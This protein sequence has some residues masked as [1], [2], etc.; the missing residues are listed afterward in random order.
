MTIQRIVKF[1]SNVQLDVF[2]SKKL[3]TVEPGDGLDPSRAAQAL[4][5]RFRF[6]YSFRI[7]R[8]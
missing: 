6:P 8:I 1:P 3:Q 5:N 4:S 2:E 7:G